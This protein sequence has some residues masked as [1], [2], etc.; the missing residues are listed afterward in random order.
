M[1]KTLFSARMLSGKSQAELARSMGV[2]RTHIS[3][4]E[5]GRSLP[6]P[7]LLWRYAL[8]VGMSVQKLVHIYDFMSSPIGPI[9]EPAGAVSQGVVHV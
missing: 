8:G 3:K 2:P 9:P 7:D 6:R 4:L 5:R 1:A